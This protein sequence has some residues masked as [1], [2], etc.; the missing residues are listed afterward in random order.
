MAYLGDTQGCCHLV[1]TKTSQVIAVHKLFD[2]GKKIDG[3]VLVHDPAA[4][5]FYVCAFR[6]YR[7]KVAVLHE[8]HVETPVKHYRFQDKI[9]KATTF[10]RGVKDQLLLC[11]F[12]SLDQATLAAMNFTYLAEDEQVLG[13]IGLYSEVSL[14]GRDKARLWKHTNFTHIVQL[15][16]KVLCL[17][18]QRLKL[19][20]KR[21]EAEATE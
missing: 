15:G 8:T 11:L 16:S 18:Q 9:V 14:D 5:S 3:L 6:Q 7:R 4:V 21:Q 19:V 17:G 13:P 2:E 20:E 10:D 1:N 12:H